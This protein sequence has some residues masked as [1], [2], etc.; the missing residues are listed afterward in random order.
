MLAAMLAMFRFEVGMFPVLAACSAAG[1]LY[2]V[3]TGAP[4]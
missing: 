1:I 3:A 4:V 2:F